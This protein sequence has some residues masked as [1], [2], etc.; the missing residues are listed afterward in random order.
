MT[1]NKPAWTATSR[2]LRSQQ[3]AGIEAVAM[4]MWEP[5]RQLRRRAILRRAREKIVFDR[6]HIMKHMIEA[7]DAVR[8]REHRALLAPATRRLTGTKYLWL[9]SE[10]NLPERHREWFVASQSL[11]LKTGRAW[12]IKESLRAPVVLSRRA[13]PQALWQHWYFWATHSRLKPVI[14]RASPQPPPPKLLSYF[15]PP[16]TNAAAEG[17]NLRR[18]TNSAWDQLLPHPCTA[19]DRSSS[20][21]TRTCT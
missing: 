12:A 1:A 6:F 4:D 21:R 11:H 10:E 17:L 5:L 14:K 19:S 13:G 3:L 8:K 16:I 2:R 18:V 7:V 20:A 15:E 9:F